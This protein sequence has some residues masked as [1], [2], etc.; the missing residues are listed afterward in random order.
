[1]GP[2]RLTGSAGGR[3]GGGFDSGGVPSG[4]RGLPHSRVVL[5]RLQLVELRLGFPL[6]FL[7]GCHLLL[8][9]VM[10]LHL[11]HLRPLTIFQPSDSW[12]NY[13]VIIQ[14]NKVGS[15]AGPITPKDNKCQNQLKLLAV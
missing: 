1:V 7:F 12:P 2:S 14:P 5:T 15:W 4:L 8:R 6:F 3:V 9:W 10:G 13:M 11:L